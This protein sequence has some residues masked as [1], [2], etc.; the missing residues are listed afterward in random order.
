MISDTGGRGLASALF[1]PVR[2][3][4]EI[5]TKVAFGPIDPSLIGDMNDRSVQF[6]F[7]KATGAIFHEAM[8]ARFTN[9]DHR[10][11]AEALTDNEHDAMQVLEESRI[12]GLGMIYHPENKP[13]LRS[14]ALEIV[15]ADMGEKN[16]KKMSRIRQAAEVAA[17]TMGRVDAG[18]LEKDDI[19][20]ITKAIKL[21]LP[22]DVLKSLRSIWRRFQALHHAE[23]QF[24]DMF[25]LAKEW[26]H[27]LDEAASEEDKA[28]AEEQAALEAAMEA[29]GKALGISVG[30]I[31]IRAQREVSNQQA[32]ERREA[33][34]K[35][36]QAREAEKGLAKDASAR[37]FGYN[38]GPH[39]GDKTHSRLIDKHAPSEA[40]R[41]AA[42]VV[43]RALEKAKYHDRIEIRAGSVFPPGRLRTRTVVQ[44]KAYEAHDIKIQLEPWRRTQRKHDVD[45]NLTVGIMVDISSS[46]TSAMMPMGVTAWVLSEAVRRIQATAAMVYYGESVFQGLAPGER[47]PEVKIY[48]ASDGTEEFAEGFKALDGKLTLLNGTGARLVVVVSDGNYRSDQRIACAQWLKRCAEEGVAVLWIGYGR[49]SAGQSMCVKAGAQFVYPADT[50]AE[51]AKLVGK[52][53]ADA[54]TAISARRA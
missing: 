27:L 49:A 20:D 45:P 19:T 54:L 32:I 4:I 37:V 24:A 48:S 43:A 1:D 31:E 16:L 14:C 25:K 34:E 36:N 51:T 52:A 33:Q 40:E 35:I 8:H 29:L 50:A 7:A 30:D 47:L 5:N 11:A 39:T 13:F 22:K 38:S 17:L 46:M 26:A 23:R 15:M 18:V 41:N 44:Q 21:I 12:E 28:D 42:V 53:A 9:H 2:H 10:A 3:E 6:E